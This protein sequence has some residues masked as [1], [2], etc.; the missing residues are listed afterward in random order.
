MNTGWNFGTIL[1]TIKK[2][3]GKEN[4]EHSQQTVWIVI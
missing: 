2:P 3:P 4:V 1:D